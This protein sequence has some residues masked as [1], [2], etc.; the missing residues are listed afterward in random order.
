MRTRLSKDSQVPPILKW[1][2]NSRDISYYLSFKSYSEGY[3]GDLLRCFAGFWQDKAA[4]LSNM[5]LKRTY[6]T[7]AVIP[8][9]IVLACCNIWETL[10]LFKKTFTCLVIVILVS[11]ISHQ[12]SIVFHQTNI[13]F[14]GEHGLEAATLVTTIY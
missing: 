14:I 8:T 1:K 2:L 11:T 13:R 7:F 10:N 12:V 4:A 6:K 9:I 5:Q 3:K